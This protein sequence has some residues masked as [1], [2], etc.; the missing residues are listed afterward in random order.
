E[1]MT[2]FEFV[3][4]NPFVGTNLRCPPGAIFSYR[5]FGE[6]TVVAGRLPYSSIWPNRSYCRS[7]MYRFP[8]VVK[9]GLS[10]KQM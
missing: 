10:D 7:R 2:A 3:S 5:N 9:H 4:I 8:R 1:T 6:K